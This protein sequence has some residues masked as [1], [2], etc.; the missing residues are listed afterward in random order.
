MAWQANVEVTVEQASQPE[1]GI[2]DAA[3]RSQGDKRKRYSGTTI[4]HSRDCISR[5]FEAMS[6][7][8]LKIEF[9]VFVC[10]GRN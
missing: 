2:S 1:R 4:D 6:G 5:T 10:E 3:S 8:A 9:S 7:P